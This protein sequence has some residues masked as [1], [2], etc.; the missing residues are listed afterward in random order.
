[1]QETS[2]LVQKNFYLALCPLFFLNLVSQKMSSS[3]SAP[4][5]L[6]ILD[7]AVPSTEG[8]VGAAAPGG[9][10]GVPCP[11]FTVTP[12][13]LQSRAL[14]PVATC[15]DHRLAQ[16]ARLLELRIA[17]ASILATEVLLPRAE[18]CNA[19][20]RSLCI[21]TR[22]RVSGRKRRYDLDQ[23]VNNWTATS[24]L[25]NCILGTHIACRKTSKL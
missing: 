6:T 11:A 18:L 8:V 3:S 7:C 9:G 17:P 2:V 1:M 13:L 19:C 23:R 15:M 14:G 25:E 21:M 10:A 4:T 16:G 20:A 24:T 22:A 5:L 12:S